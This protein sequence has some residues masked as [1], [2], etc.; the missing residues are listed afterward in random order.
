M[1]A[2]THAKNAGRV[3]GFLCSLLFL[4]APYI[5]NA[6]EIDL[7]LKGGHVIDPKN[8]INTVMDVAVAGGKIVRVASNI[9]A[10][11]AKKTVDVK[12]FYVTPGLIDMHAHV[13]AGTVPDAYIANASTSLPPDGFTFRAGITTVVDAGSSGWR[14]FRTFKAQTIDK[15]Q[16]RVLA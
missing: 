15:A 13:F 12:G 8:N 1:L 5:S 2:C 11:E 3:A 4:F 9:A 16:T 6:Q 10:S 7:L 14:N